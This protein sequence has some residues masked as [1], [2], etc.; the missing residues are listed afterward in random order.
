MEPKSVV[1]NSLATQASDPPQNILDS[2]DPVEHMPGKLQRGELL[3]SIAGGQIAEHKL[4]RDEVIAALNTHGDEWK[5]FWI[6]FPDHVE[7]ELTGLEEQWEIE[8]VGEDLEK[9]IVAKAFRRYLRKRHT[10]D[11]LQ[12][13]G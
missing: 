7:S 4:T 12:R 9:A 5:I 13:N 2:S 10:S 3:P 6:D 1:S 8:P 11:G